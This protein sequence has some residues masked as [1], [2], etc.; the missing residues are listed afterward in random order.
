MTSATFSNPKLGWAAVLAGVPL[1]LLLRKL[2]RRS[3]RLSVLPR[4]KERVLI[5]GA[6]RY[7]G[8]DILILGLYLNVDEAALVVLLRNNTH[9]KVP[10]SV[11]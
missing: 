3:R 8:Q 7:V 4:S 11:L 1:L 6:S 10:V 2:L 9:R 5:L